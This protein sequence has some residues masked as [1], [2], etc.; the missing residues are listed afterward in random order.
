MV[1]LIL[2]LVRANLYCLSNS[3]IKWT[4]VE[5]LLSPFLNPCY[6]GPWSVYSASKE[7][8]LLTAEN[9]KTSV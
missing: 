1:N 2:L 7:A 5:I 4:V 6:G 9:C 3:F 8:A